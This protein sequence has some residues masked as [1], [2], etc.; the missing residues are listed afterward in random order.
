MIHNRNIKCQVERM[1]SNKFILWGL[2]KRSGSGVTRARISGGGA[3]GDAQ[4][5]LGGIDCSSSHFSS[6]YQFFKLGGTWGALA[7]AWGGERAPHQLCLTVLGVANA[8][9]RRLLVMR[10]MSKSTHSEL[11]R[12]HLLMGWGPQDFSHGHYYWGTISK[13]NID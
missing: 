5:L 13:Q 12:Q 3:P 6:R 8:M 7:S 2:W 10:L 9:N 11:L 1:V 4:T